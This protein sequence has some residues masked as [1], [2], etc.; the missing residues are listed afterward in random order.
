MSNGYQQLYPAQPE[1]KRGSE[2]PQPP[3]RPGPD[4][5]Q[6]PPPAAEPKTDK[7][8]TVG[9][10][11][12]VLFEDMPIRV[13]VQMH[14]TLD[15]L[16]ALKARLKKLGL[17]P[18]PAPV[19]WTPEGLPIC[20]RHGV[21]MDRRD[22]QKDVWYSHK[23]KDVDGNVILDKRGQPIFCRGCAGKSSPGWDL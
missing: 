3:P 18:V 5:R 7:A 2:I 14:L 19:V 13:H 4:A 12:E 9:I 16:K 11:V 21:V 17:D 15:K 22:V 8:S 6:A 20:P 23:L 10:S 1:L